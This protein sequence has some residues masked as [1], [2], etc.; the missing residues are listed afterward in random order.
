MAGHL[1]DTRDPHEVAG[2]SLP[3]SS[4][5]GSSHSGSSHPGL[6]SGAGEMGAIARWVDERSGVVGALPR[7]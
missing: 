7:E 6:S 1:P 5:S 3:G 2:S 4:H